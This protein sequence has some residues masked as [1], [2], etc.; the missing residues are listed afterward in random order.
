[1]TAMSWVAQRVMKL[2]R[3]ETRDVEVVRDLAVPMRDGVELLADRWFPKVSDAEQRPVLLCRTPYGRARDGVNA[4]L[5]AER[6]YQVVVVSCRGTFGSGGEFEPLFNEASDGQDTFAWLAGQPW[7]GPDATVGTFGGSY[8]GHTQWAIAADP[9]P[10]SASSPAWKAMAPAATTANFNDLFHP[11]GTFALAT[12]VNWFHVVEHQ[13]LPTPRRLLELVRGGKAIAAGVHAAPMIDA[14]LATVGHAVPWYRRWVEE[15]DPDGEYWGRLRWREQ[16][17]TQAPPATFV[18]G[19]YDLFL[20]HQLADYQALRDA[21]RDVELTIGPWHHIA[22]GLNFAAIRATLAWMD[23]HLRSRAPAAPAA[24]AAS[25]TRRAPVRIFVPRSTRRRTG[26]WVDLPSWPPPSEPQRWH[27]QPGGE[28][29]TTPAPA[30]SPDRY[31]YDPAAP[32]PV[33]GGATL[34]AR[35]IG[36]KEQRRTERHADVLTYTSEAFDDDATFVGPV[37]AELHLR[38]EVAHTDVFVRLCVV[39]DKDRSFNVCDGIVRLEVEPEV[40]FVA[41]VE[42]LPTAVTVAAGHRIRVQVASGAHPTADANLGSGPGWREVHHDPDH[43]S[44]I[45]LPVCAKL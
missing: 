24:P 3:P 27:L 22:P 39:D 29:A 9:P 13:E 31:R 25:A 4:R 32:T 38:S 8:V 20:P 18:A 36:R 10:A 23:Q 15:T 40:P 2:P 21:G 16:V 35:N 45:T 41:T 5:F 34:D 7:A 33:V 43:P 28:L 1:M 44:S 6:G 17:A 14:D 42:L 37:G 11:G 26:R 19:W 30:S 12:V